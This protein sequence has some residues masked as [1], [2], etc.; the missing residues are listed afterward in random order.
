MMFFTEVRLQTSAACRAWTAEHGCFS[1]IEWESAQNALPVFRHAFESARLRISETLAVEGID[2]LGIVRQ[3]LI[4]ESAS[5]FSR[6]GLREA[7]FVHLES[8][9]G[10]HLYALWRAYEFAL[11]R[12]SARAAWGLRW[13]AFLRAFV[14]L[15]IWMAVFA[16]A[17]FRPG[18]VRPLI[19]VAVR[20]AAKRFGFR[21]SAAAPI[22]IALLFD[23]TIGFLASFGTENRFADW[24][25]G[26]LHYALAWWGG[27]LGYE[28]AR[29]R[30]FGSFGVHFALSFASWIAVLPIDLMQGSFAPAT[31]FLSWV[32]VEFLVR[33]G[34]LAFFLCAL[35]TGFAASDIAGQIFQWGS[36]FENRAV[37]WI[38]GWL[39]R[40]GALRL[41]PD[42]QGP[43]LAWSFA[44]GVIAF[45]VGIPRAAPQKELRL[46]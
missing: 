36:F 12:I 13:T 34:Y 14:P 39:A 6:S 46:K 37:G 19:L 10:I 22:F 43:L 33:G 21:W 17:G 44:F 20:W 45:S 18:L 26:E 29:S 9:S 5:P 24:A 25:P 4:H 23:A 1:G 27:V 35:L 41:I 40:A 8:S 31:P 15:G 30:G 38:F 11:A 16:L 28:W 42:E 32:T 2:P 7:G 3:L